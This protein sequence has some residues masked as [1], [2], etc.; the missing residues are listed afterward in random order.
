MAG[1]LQLDV[2][3]NEKEFCLDAELPGYSKEDTRLEIAND[4]LRIAVK[5]EESLDETKG[6]FIHRERRLAP[7]SAPFIW[8][9]WMCRHPGKV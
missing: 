1:Y 6:N 3:E 4:P 5:R 7:R 2:R 9:T 8:L